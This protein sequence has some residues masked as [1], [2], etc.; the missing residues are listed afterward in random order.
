MAFFN[1]FSYDTVENLLI[2]LKMGNL[3]VHKSATNRYP[4]QSNFDLNTNFTVFCRL[5]SVKENCK[6]FMAAA[7][8]T[9][10]Q[11]IYMYTN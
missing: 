10:T 11:Q 9:V 5:G 3:H 6:F 8:L 4:W 1:E 7:K 2:A